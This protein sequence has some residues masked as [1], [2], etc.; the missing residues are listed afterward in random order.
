MVRV[1]L[2]RALPLSILVVLGC[3]RA[4]RPG[5]QTGTEIPSALTGPGPG[6]CVVHLHGKG[7]R[8]ARPEVVDG[9]V[10][11]WPDGNGEG[12]GG[13]QW[14]YFPDARYLEVRRIISD[15][16]T[17]ASCTQALLHGSSNG[18]SAAASLYCRSETFD[19]KLVGTIIDDPVPDH[20]VENCA[21][22][23][24]AR[25]RLYVT[26]ALA[27]QGVPGAR[28][29]ALDWTCQGG[30]TIGIEAYARLLGASP[31]RSANTEHAPIR[32]PAEYHDW[33]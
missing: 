30:S 2:L 29:A 20:G 13:R 17:A 16:I 32:D 6:R 1:S 4:A 33:W 12:W 31:V 18:A 10:H 11:L 8:G 27:N 19:G 21:P 28:C 14:V 9:L 3:H 15:A 23:P 26:G 5:A 24:R 7:A 22:S 25:L